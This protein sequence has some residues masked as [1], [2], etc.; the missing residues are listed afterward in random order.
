VFSGTYLAR[1]AR[2]T[3]RLLQALAIVEYWNLH[4]EMFMAAQKQ[5]L[6]WM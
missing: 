4:P 5:Q 6:F 2:K 3:Y 1:T